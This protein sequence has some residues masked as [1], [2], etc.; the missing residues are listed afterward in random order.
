MQ[1]TIDTSKLLED[2]ES[3]KIKNVKLKLQN[4]LQK[5]RLR[6]LKKLNFRRKKKTHNIRHHSPFKNKQLDGL[7]FKASSLLKHLFP[8]LFGYYALRNIKKKFLKIIN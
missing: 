5:E 1:E 7:N 8:L 6:P 4:S 3:E 2:L